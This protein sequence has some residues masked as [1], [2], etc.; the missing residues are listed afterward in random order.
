MK[1]LHL[2]CFVSV[3]STHWESDTLVQTLLDF[4]HKQKHGAWQG[5]EQLRQSTAG[6]L[7]VSWGS[8]QEIPLRE[9][10]QMMHGGS[11]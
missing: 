2:H 9:V 7:R 5:S 3:W 4:Y 1:A 8:E 10:Q 6:L 11:N